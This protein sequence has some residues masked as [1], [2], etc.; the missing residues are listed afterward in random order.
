[1][2]KKPEISKVSDFNQFMLWSSVLLFIDSYLI[3]MDNKSIYSLT[4]E[5]I[6]IH[7]GHLPIMLI[8]YLFSMSTMSIVTQQIVNLILL[9]KEILFQ[10]NYKKE[11]RN[12][13]FF[14]DALLNLAIIK[15]N[16]ILYDRYKKHKK[17]VIKIFEQQKIASG[18]VFISVIN[19][20]ISN[21]ETISLLKSY[22]LLLS[23]KSLWYIDI[24]HII[25]LF[26]ILYILII[27]FKPCDSF[28]YV[29]LDKNIKDELIK[30]N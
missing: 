23:D 25:P 15:N 14:D 4:F 13:Y 20:F 30:Q 8:L 6:K 11:D 28:Y 24:L 10:N 21:N 1:M 12:D 29:N 19:Y 7:L 9:I 2:F 27:A 16:T 17:T 22:S 3:L 18:L 5:Y 26:T